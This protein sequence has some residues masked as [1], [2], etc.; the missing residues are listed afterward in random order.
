M[1]SRRDLAAQHRDD[2]GSGHPAAIVPI[3]VAEPKDIAHAAIDHDPAFRQARLDLAGRVESH[4]A[5]RRRIEQQA[6]R[7][8]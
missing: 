3:G 6:R 4:Q 5:L 2:L 7:G 1:R 8:I